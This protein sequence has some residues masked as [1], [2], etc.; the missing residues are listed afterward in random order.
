MDMGPNALSHQ[1]MAGGA[2]GM[3]RAGERRRRTGG[4]GGVSFLSALAVVVGV[5]INLSGV[6]AQCGTGE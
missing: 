6:K 3:G 4:S 1:G 5:A 2:D